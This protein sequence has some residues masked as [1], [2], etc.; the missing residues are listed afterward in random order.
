MANKQQIELVVSTE[1]QDR[2]PRTRDIDLGKWLE[3]PDPAHCRE[4]I[5]RLLKAKKLNDSDIIRVPRE[6]SLG[7]GGKRTV[8]EFHL[9]REEALKVAVLSGKPK[10]LVALDELIRVFLAAQRLGYLEQRILQFNA[11]CD[12]DLMWSEA[13]LKP[14][15]DL[16]GWPVFVNGRMYQPIAGIIHLL[17]R[18]SLGDDVM[19]EIK[20][21]NPKPEFEKN[22]H[23]LMAKETREL[24]RNDLHDIAVIASTSNRR[25][26]FW[27]KLERHFRKGMLQTSFDDYRPKKLTGKKSTR[28]K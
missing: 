23:Q 28:K 21:R 13:E 6:S 5:K 22:H 7:H 9:R 11:R 8:I 26:D 19:D 14:I 20:K 18:L 10:G 12:W 24:F 4:L 27:Q 17:Y 25:E 2:E 1:Y 16:Y 15:C 3:Y